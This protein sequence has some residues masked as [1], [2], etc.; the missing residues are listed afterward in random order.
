[1]SRP[2]TDEE[3]EHLLSF[4]GYG[5]LSAPIWFLGMEEGGGGE[6]NLRRRLSFE[7]IEDLYEGHK[8]LGI[9]K[10]HE[11][12]RKIQPTWRGMCVIMLN[13]MGEDPTT[14]AIRAFQAERLGRSSS[15]TFLLEL[16]PL[17]KP[18]MDAWDY[19]GLLP[20]FGSKED[21]YEQILPQRVEYLRSLIDRHSPAAVIGFGKSYWHHYRKLFPTSEFKSRKI[22]EIAGGSPFVLLSHHF[23]AR[24]MNGRFSEI[25]RIVRDGIDAS[26]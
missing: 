5:N 15:N 2:F 20:Q 21:Y 1:M 17:P 13:L 19:D 24:S 3:V 26:A 6:E 7:R 23:T 10:H 8:K 18:N 4:V 9:L 14:D 12:Y 25:A 16:M 22:Y 11:G